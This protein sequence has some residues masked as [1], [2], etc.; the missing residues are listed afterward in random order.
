MN[1]LKVVVIVS[2]DPSDIYF[3]N[4]LAR[5]LN[6]VGIIVESSAEQPDVRRKIGKLA[7]YAFSPWQI[8]RLLRERAIVREHVRRTSAIDLVGFGIDAFELTPPPSCRVERVYGKNA[9]NSPE[10]VELIREFEPDLLVLCGCS[11]LKEPVLSIP[12][13]GSLNL[14]GGLAQRYR[15]VWTTLWAVVNE[16]PEY[17][18]ATVHF[19]NSGIDDGDIV[20]Q[21]RPEV[22]ADDDPESLYVKVVKL[23][24]RMMITAVEDIEVGRVQRHKLEQKGRLYLSRMVTPEVLHK[25]WTLTEGGVI[26]RYLA[27]R[28]ERDAR[29]LEIMRG[30]YCT[31]GE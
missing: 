9:A 20:Y 13:L 2:S 15:G 14:H 22:A 12:R 26:S 19:V 25:A 29:V 4:Q 8:P 18:G 16:E 11:I 30:V 24:V 28:G 23:G 5:R 31:P 3:A 6:V 1:R 21:G 17:V 10:T 7:G 27:A